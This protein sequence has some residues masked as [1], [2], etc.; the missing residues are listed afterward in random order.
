MEILCICCLVVLIILVYYKA[1]IYLKIYSGHEY[2]QIEFYLRK[3]FIHVECNKTLY[4]S[5]DYLIYLQLRD[6][7]R[8]REEH[9]CYP[10]WRGCASKDVCRYIDLRS[11]MFQFS[12]MKGNWT[13]QEFMMCRY[14]EGSEKSFGAEGGHGCKCGSNCTCDPCNC[15]SQKHSG[16]GYI[17]L[18]TQILLFC[19]VFNENYIVQ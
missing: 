16:P 13:I 4:S 9:N 8:C 2:W 12:Y 1:A 7:S 5:I 17:C 3:D 11:L 6:V 19:K 15:W 10:H 18:K 14:S